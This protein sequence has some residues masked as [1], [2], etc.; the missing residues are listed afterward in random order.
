[1]LGLIASGTTLLFP[2]GFDLAAFGL[3]VIALLASLSV[4]AP[5]LLRL[6]KSP[7]KSLRRLRTVELLDTYNP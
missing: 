5:E 3:L 6:P 4:L 1:M 2:A 7:P